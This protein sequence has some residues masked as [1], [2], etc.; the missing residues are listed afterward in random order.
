MSRVNLT[1]KRVDEIVLD[2]QRVPSVDEVDG[3]IVPDL[4]VTVQSEEPLEGAV[5]G[6]VEGDG[7]EAVERGLSKEILVVVGSDVYCLAETWGT[8]IRSSPTSAKERWIEHT[9]SSKHVNLQGLTDRAH[10]GCFHQ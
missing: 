3:D 1:G 6:V 4:E 10:Q 5:H 2:E 8:L 7:I 9:R